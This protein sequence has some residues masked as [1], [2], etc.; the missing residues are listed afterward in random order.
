MYARHGVSVEFGS[1]PSRRAVH[2]RTASLLE[3]TVGSGGRIRLALM[4]AALR[5]E[6]DKLYQ[7]VKEVV[8]RIEVFCCEFSPAPPIY[9]GPGMVGLCYVPEDI[10]DSEGVS[11]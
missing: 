1:A 11:S 2:R 3:R 4:H 5:Q 8:A 7:V 10:L 9:T 6:A